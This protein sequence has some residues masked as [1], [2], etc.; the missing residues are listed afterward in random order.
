MTVIKMLSAQMSDLEILCVIVFLG[1]QEM[2]SFV[3][4]GCGVLCT[5]I[6]INIYR[7]SCREGGFYNPNFP[8]QIMAKSHCPRLCRAH[9]YCFLLVSPSA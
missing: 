7:E 8:A 2:E 4:V 1:M 9:F 5:R 6:Y 3:Q